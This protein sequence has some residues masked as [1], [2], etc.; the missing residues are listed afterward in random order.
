M[1]T[2]H[3]LDLPYTFQLTPIER[4]AVRYTEEMMEPVNAEELMIAEVR[5]DQCSTFKTRELVI[6][7]IS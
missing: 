1:V 2:K 5:Y 4:Y 6:C 7:G 3:M